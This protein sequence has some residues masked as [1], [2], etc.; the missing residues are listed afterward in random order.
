MAEERPGGFLPP[1]PPGPEPELGPRPPAPPPAAPQAPQAPQAPPPGYWQPAP[2]EP[3]N[4]PAVAGFVLSVVSGGLV[5]V[6]FGLSSIISVGCAVAGIL[7]S[8]EGRRKVAAGETRKHAGLAQ[9]GFI[10]GIV[11]LVISV[12]AT[13]A[14]AVVIFLLATDEE[15]RDDFEDDSGGSDSVG[16]PARA[17]AGAARLAL[18][19]LA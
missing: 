11:S 10:V 3:D 15:F 17:L 5:L 19:L 18:D 14:W 2:P 9:A 6:S 13:L 12:L 7:Q 1:E 4:G 16:I 8:R